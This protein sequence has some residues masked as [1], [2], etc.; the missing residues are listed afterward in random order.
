MIS[1]PVTHAENTA[2]K[3]QNA[4]GWRQLFNGRMSKMWSEIQDKYLHGIKL[5]TRCPNGASWVKQVIKLIW[6]QFHILWTHCNE[7]CHG[8]NRQGIKEHQREILLTKVEA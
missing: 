1:I 3:Q 8:K 7:T 4:V 6:Q 2:I 5:H